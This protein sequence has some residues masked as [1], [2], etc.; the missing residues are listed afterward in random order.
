MGINIVIGAFYLKRMI[1]NKGQNA[2]GHRDILIFGGKF[3]DL[4]KTAD[5][6]ERNDPANASL[7][8]VAAKVDHRFCG[9]QQAPTR[10]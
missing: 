9:S 2:R 8:P 5:T 6:A 3:K 10:L 7:E 4:W 1:V